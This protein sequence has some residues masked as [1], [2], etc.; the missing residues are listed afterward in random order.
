LTP[1]TPPPPLPPPPPPAKRAETRPRVL[2]LSSL[3]PL[4][5]VGLWAPDMSVLAGCE[6]GL[7]APGDAPLALT[8]QAV[9]AYAPEVLV[10]ADARAGG[11]ARVFQGL[12]AAAALPGWWALPAVK[13]G[14]V[15]VCDA[16]LMGRAGPRLVDGVEALARMAHGDAVATCCP[17]GAVMKLSLR[18]GQR[19]RPR[20]LPNYFMAYS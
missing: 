19:C 13:A 8:W 2:V 4:A 9:L 17:P 12:C 15:F 11:E 5:T 1:L 10:L 18:P 20:L 7:Q 3:D 6:D 16:A 14:A